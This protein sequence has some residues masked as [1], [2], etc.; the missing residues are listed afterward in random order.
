MKDQKTRYGATAKCPNHQ[1]A[2]ISNTDAT[3]ALRGKSIK[4]FLHDIQYVIPFN[5]TFYVCSLPL[6]K[7]GDGM[8][9]WEEDGEMR[10]AVR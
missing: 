9:R 1:N 8:G 5:E 2:Q 3:D 4:L 10:G 6:Y 7:Q